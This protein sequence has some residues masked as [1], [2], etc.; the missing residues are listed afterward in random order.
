MQAYFVLP[1][2]SALYYRKH[3]PDYR[4]LPPLHPDCTQGQADISVIEL[5]Y[6]PHNSR[7]YVPRELNGTSSRAV[8]YA[9]HRSQ[10]ASVYWYLD[11]QFL[12]NTREFHT[13]EIIAKP[14]QHQITIVDEHGERVSRDFEIVGT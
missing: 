13:M 12:G 5:I 14:G 8:F 11:N 1:P 10:T 2:A 3:H 7:I 9:A 6:P 4:S